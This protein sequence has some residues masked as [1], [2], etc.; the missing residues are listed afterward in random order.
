MTRWIKVCILLLWAWGMMISSGFAQEKAKEEPPE[1]PTETRTQI[2]SIYFGGGSHY[3]DDEQLKELR[4]FLN[5][6]GIQLIRID[7]ANPP[8]NMQSTFFTALAPP[9]EVKQ[10]LRTSCFDCH[11][12]DTK[13][14]WYTNVA[15][16]SWWI[17][18]HIN[19]AREEMNFSEWAAYS[20]RKKNHK[21]EEIVELVNTGEMPLPSYLIVHRESRLTKAQIATLTQWVFQK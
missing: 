9:D 5:E 8:V 14:P 16:L 4:N 20:D 12:N 11:S 18:Y 19:H 10:I 15:P 1:K 17:K 7:K 13:Y 2:K 21:L 6:L 3:V